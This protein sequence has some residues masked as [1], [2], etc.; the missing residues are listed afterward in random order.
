M[1]GLLLACGIALNGA[2]QTPD[3]V[4]EL[5]KAQ[6]LFDR[7]ITLINE[8]QYDQALPL[9]QQV[10]EIRQRLLAPDDI[11]LGMAL[12][13]LA[14]LCLVKKKEQ[15][16]EKA[17]RRALAVYESHSEQNQLAISKTL[18]RLS[19]LR[20]LKRD[21]TSAEP[22]AWHALLITE[23]ELGR[24]DPKTI[25]AM[26]NYACIGL[27]A[28]AAKGPPFAKEP[29]EHKATLRK[30]SLCWL[31]GL[32]DKCDEV[33]S[34]DIINQKA[35]KLVQPEY[36]VAARRNRLTGIVFVAIL[37]NHQGDVIVAKP[38]CSGVPELNAA[39]LAA[40]RKSRFAASNAP[41][42]QTTGIVTYRFYIK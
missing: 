6:E 15:D 10:G 3:S 1:I 21:Y 22:L 7:V 17:Y 20:F 12:S 23:K 29:D 5:A 38:V 27:L 41:G 2:S 33:Q 30:I 36:P 42:K 9:A 19:Y 13:V 35:V 32:T 39:G 40:A 28:G 16:A 18:E 34:E 31:G 8:R 25:S 4:R 24:S 11:K 26:Q 37:V 14:E